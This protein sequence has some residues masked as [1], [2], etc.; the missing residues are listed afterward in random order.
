MVLT[1]PE[2]NAG[3]IGSGFVILTKDPPLASIR[4]T[5]VFAEVAD[6]ESWKAVDELG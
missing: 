1:W 3:S 2:P 5:L 6:A 4:R